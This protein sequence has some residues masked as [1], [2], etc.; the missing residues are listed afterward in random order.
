MRG[1][2]YAFVNSNRLQNKL[3]ALSINYLHLLD[4]APTEAVRKKQ[5]DADAKSGLPVRQRT[6]LSDDYVKAYKKHIL[7]KFNFEDLFETLDILG[8]KKAV[9]F[10]IEKIPEACHR[11]LVT[12]A[13]KK[14]YGIN[15]IDL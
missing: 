15:H 13:L 9:F 14:Q 6:K 10:C 7:A 5:K 3:A 8:S 11:S 2:A 1:T 12:E 4:L